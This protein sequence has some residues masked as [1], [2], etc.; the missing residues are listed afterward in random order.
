MIWMESYRLFEFI[1]IC[2]KIR[3]VL[4]ESYD[5]LMESIR[6]PFDLKD[7]HA[8]FRCVSGP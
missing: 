8:I 5:C 2:F 4:L 7:V 3:Q 6:L 1:M